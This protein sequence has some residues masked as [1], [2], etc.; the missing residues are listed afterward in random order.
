[1]LWDGAIRVRMSD[2]RQDILSRVL[3]TGHQ[4]FVAGIVN[5]L[6]L[7]HHFI[8]RIFDSFFLSQS[9]S[10]A[11]IVFPLK[12]VSIRTM[13]KEFLKVLVPEQFFS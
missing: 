2:L 4:I 12:Y 5:L 9:F 7:L 13:L 6:L 3:S 1:M 10:S 8:L 11:L